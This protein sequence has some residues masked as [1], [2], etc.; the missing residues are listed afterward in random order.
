M[1]EPR[2]QHCKTASANFYE[3]E[4]LEEKEVRKV[5]NNVCFR[6]DASNARSADGHIA[7]WLNL[8]RS[9]LFC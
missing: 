7:K 4:E 1:G 5:L 2:K 9:E 8:S 6:A 3:Y